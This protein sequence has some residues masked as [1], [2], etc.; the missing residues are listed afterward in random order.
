MIVTPRLAIDG[1]TSVRTTP[2]PSWP[3]FGDEDVESVARVL[4]SGRV[5]YWTGDECAEFE[6]EHAAATKRVHAISVANGT[7]A[8]ELALR[9]FGIGP[10]DEVVVPARTFIATAGAA[11]AVGATPVIADV[12]VESGCLTADSVRDVLTEQTRA[13]MPVH[14][15]GWPADMPSIMALAAE[16]ELVVVEDCAQAHGAGCE[17]RP[18]GSFG[19][20]AVFSFCQDKIIP[21]GEGGMLVL[22]DDD[23]YE[24]AWSYK[25]HGK[26]RTKVLDA[27]GSPSTEF[28]WLV[29]SWGS[30]FRML[31][32]TAAMGRLRLARLPEWHARRA[33]HAMRIAE[34]LRDLAGVRVPL[35]DDGLEHGFYRLYGLIESSGLTS[36]WTRDRVLS[37]IAAEGVPVQYGTCA[38]IYR[39]PVFAA[40]GLGPAK[41][42]PGASDIHGRSIAFFVHPTLADEDIEDTLTA[43][44]KVLEVACG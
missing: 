21:L 24:R 26:S 23:A 44:R 35:P 12:D 37:A 22:D 18:V 42:L 30:N 20:A 33:Q 19:H 9:A 27:E 29:D 10:G 6:S 25:D 11:A 16:R 4:R 31:E 41:R 5:N 13:V 2:M 32:T 8:L 7:L 43:V 36:G 28:K 15:G 38:E 39:E 1:G 14:V 17:G 3:V 34:G 40:T